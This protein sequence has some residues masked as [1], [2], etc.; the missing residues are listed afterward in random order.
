[1][2]YVEISGLRLSQTTLLAIAE[3]VMAHSLWLTLLAIVNCRCLRP[4]A[5]RPSWVN[6]WR[7]H[8][9]VYGIMAIAT[10]I[11]WVQLGLIM[12]PKRIR[13]NA[14]GCEWSDEHLM[15]WTMFQTFSLSAVAFVCTYCRRNPVGHMI[16]S[17]IGVHAMALMGF[18][19]MGMA[20][21][22]ACASDVFPL[23]T[24]MIGMAFMC[25]CFPWYMGAWQVPH[26]HDLEAEARAEVV[27]DEREV[28]TCWGWRLFE[29]HL[30]RNPRPYRGDD[31]GGGA[32]ALLDADEHE[33]NRIATLLFG[34]SAVH[35]D[36]KANGPGVEQQHH[37]MAEEVRTVGEQRDSDSLSDD[38]DDD[39]DDDDNGYKEE[40][41]EDSSEIVTAKG[42]G[43]GN[44]A[45]PLADLPSVSETM[46]QEPFVANPQQWAASNTLSSPSS[47]GGR[48]NTSRKKRG[49]DKG[50]EK[51]T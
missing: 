11:M 22:G 34:S 47:S 45:V 17:Y 36:R 40:I 21:Q 30:R 44:G 23:L 19:M 18:S 1:M 32:A 2:F 15:A 13:D 29:R 4:L 51:K 12:G 28:L 16:T 39:D 49:A 33:Q 46:R 31:G 5:P 8:T 25:C 41:P 43:R 38:D 9:T 42:D 27:D 10:E 14:I 48:E 37:Y 24:A 26:P 35:K 50:K 3:G 7:V 20:E 6:A